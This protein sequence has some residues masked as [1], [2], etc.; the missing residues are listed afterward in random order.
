MDGPS[1]M[2]FVSQ[3]SWNEDSEAVM[4]NDQRR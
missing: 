2:P 4:E 1:W 3:G